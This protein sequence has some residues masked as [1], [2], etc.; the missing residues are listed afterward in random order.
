MGTLSVNIG[1]EEGNIARE[2]QFRFKHA[3]QMIM[4]PNQRDCYVCHMVR[5][6]FVGDSHK[7]FLDL[8]FEP[9][10][11]LERG[12]LLDKKGFTEEGSFLSKLLGK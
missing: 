10:K 2:P 1:L 9:W 7:Q 11:I 5:V 8:R 12:M 6:T 3:V 4:L